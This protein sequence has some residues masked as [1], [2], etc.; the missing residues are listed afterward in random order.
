MC[1][2][3][4][5]QSTWENRKIILFQVNQ[6]NTH[7]YISLQQKDQRNFVNE[8]FTYK[9]GLI[10]FAIAEQS[11]KEYKGDKYTM[12]RDCF[13]E[14][15]FKQGIYLAYIETT[16]QLQQA[17]D[18]VIS[19]Y[20]SSQIK[21]LYKEV[22]DPNL[23]DKYLDN[24]IKIKPP[25]QKQLK[26]FEQ[27]HNVQR[28]QIDLGSY[29]AFSYS[30]KSQSSTL[31]ETVTMNQLDCLEICPPQH[32]PSQFEVTIGPG[33]EQV[34][35]YRIKPEKNGAFGYGLQIMTKF[36]KKC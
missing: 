8:N 27:D 26:V 9:C 3:D 19:A 11:F 4:R 1:I 20:S 10:S 13:I 14:T 7:A 15:T 35:K 21:F 33:Q 24:L 36:Q 31:I 2:R 12:Q 6:D 22:A 5:T 23:L 32:N 29:V 25:E 17:K 16:Q 34:V 18:V 28:K 30:N